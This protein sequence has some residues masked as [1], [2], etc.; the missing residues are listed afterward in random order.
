MADSFHEES[1]LKVLRLLKADP[2]LSQRELSRTLGIS[3][4][5][6]NSCVRA[7]LN[8]GLIKMQNLRNSDNKLGYAY[9]LTPAGISAKAD[10][11]RLFLIK[12]KIDYDILRKEIDVLA[13][14]LNDI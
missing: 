6:T 14:E 12:K 1:Y 7:L 11:T 5:K 2:S 10:L 13:K 9:L 3:L 8:K 4:G